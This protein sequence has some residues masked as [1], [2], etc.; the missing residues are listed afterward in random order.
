MTE[1]KSQ[2]ELYQEYRDAY[3]QIEHKKQSLDPMDSKN[4]AKIT[5][6]NGM[7]TDLAIGMR[8]L[9]PSGKG[10]EFFWRGVSSHPGKKGGVSIA[11]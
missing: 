8:G 6:Y 10:R 1:W 2:G 9:D 3:S 7:L 4:L 5:T 11:R